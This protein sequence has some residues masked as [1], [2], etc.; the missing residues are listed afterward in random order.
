[1][2][3]Q[4]GPGPADGGFGAGPTQSIPYLAAPPGAALEPGPVGVVAFVGR[5][6]KG[7]V[8]EPVP[9]E[10]FSQFQ[11]RFG[12][13]WPDSLLPHAV[14]Q[15]FEQGGRQAVIVRVAA[16][17]RAPT[18]ELPAGGEWLTLA[19][20]SPGRH[21]FVRAS[22]DHDGIGPQDQDLFNLVVQR[23]R[24]RGSELV[25]AQ[26]IFRRV[27]ILAGSARDVS[28][29]LATS[30]LVRVAGPLPSVRPD[31]TR[32]P[33]TRAL[34]GYVECNDDGD[35]GQWLSDYDLIGSEAERSGMFAL[36]DGPRFNF[37]YLPPP[38]LDRDLGMSV[39]VVG[40]RFCRRQHALLLVDP[41]ARWTT[42]QAAFDGLAD[43]PF[44]STDALM[45]FPR[46][47]VQDRLL[48]QP[49]QF[50]PAAAAIGTLLRDGA[51]EAW[52]EDVAALLR[53]AATPAVWVDRQQRARFAQRGVN[54]LRATRTPGGGEPPYCTL[55]GELGQGPDARLLSARRL[56]LQL[57][58]GIER[59]TRWVVIEGNTARSR[60]RAARQVEE[61]LR[62]H[63]QAGAFAGT[64]RNR[65]Y[66]VLCDERLNGPLQQ[67]ADV[68][69][70]VYGF[71]SAQSPVRL[72]WLVEH[73]PDGSQ[74]RAVSLNQLAAGELG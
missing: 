13:L 71:Q 34:I 55:A 62:R 4:Q 26:E 10:D 69:R 27:S 39:L 41:P 61:F 72:S 1:M 56:A 67:A 23:V 18:I 46:V 24:A 29:K 58:A 5:A 47:T 12:G 21:E 65:H 54:A 50:P 20:T 45:F 52:H 74:T 59:G 9:V 22:V 63:A 42:A 11:Q 51:P 31:I 66:F 16:G 40:A 7:P 64:E 33:D 2:S 15:F 48:G 19:G 44:H 6:L 57:A 68:F 14:E 35:D 73:R 36:R 17:A 28:R 37:L 43:W 60:E 3:P 30:Q 32:G 25:E 38:A 70:L 49:V 53:P 8:N